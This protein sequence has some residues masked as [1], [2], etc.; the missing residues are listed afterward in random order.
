MPSYARP[1]VASEG[2][3][4]PRAVQV[5]A[6]H[7][8]QPPTAIAIPASTC[9]TPLPPNLL[10]PPSRPSTPRPPARKPTNFFDLPGELRN[11]IY[12]HSD[13]P[14]ATRRLN[15]YDSD[16]RIHPTRAIPPLLRADKRLASEARS[17]YFNAVAFDIL[18]DADDSRPFLRWLKAIGFDAQA[19][20][21]RHAR[22]TVRVVHSVQLC[23]PDMT[24]WPG[25]SR[26]GGPVTAAHV[27]NRAGAPAYVV[28]AMKR[29]PAVG[30]WCLV[31][32]CAA[33]VRGCGHGWFKTRPWG[34]VGC[35]LAPRKMVE[36][37]ASLRMVMKGVYRRL[38][39]LPPSVK[40]EVNKK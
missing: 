7:P 9:A 13:L 24:R 5:P 39:M 31:S 3:K 35:Q 15:F 26:A 27:C 38:A 22:V 6:A 34:S 18:V 40:G 11:A 12:E 14:R 30:T 20:L 10:S 29:F 17:Y 32:E 28:A 37:D 33:D 19:R 36:R 4:H 25:A 8:H 16:L 1:T 23:R 2:R 21:A